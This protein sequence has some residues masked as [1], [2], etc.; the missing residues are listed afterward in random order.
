ME[1]KKKTLR[2]GQIAKHCQVNSRT[3]HRWVNEG[4]LNSFKMPSGH[5]RV[6]KKEFRTFLL[7]HN[8]P[9]SS[10][11]FDFNEEKIL[12]VDKDKV[13]LKKTTELF[14]DAFPDSICEQAKS[15]EKAAL[16]V[17]VYRPRYVLLSLDFE[18]HLITHFVEKLYSHNILKSCEVLGVVDVSFPYK[19]PTPQISHI[20]ELPMTV[21]TLQQVL[22][23]DVYDK[24]V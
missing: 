3:V 16:M 10:D 13:R 2:V 6:T 9:L 24:G 7:E 1:S 18:N 8:F 4:K 19:R 21:K 14:R 12:I 17:G 22:R 11:F 20:I 23:T 5:F 15:L